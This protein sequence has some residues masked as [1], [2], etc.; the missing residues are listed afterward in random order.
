MTIFQKRKLDK[1]LLPVLLGSSF[2]T[3]LSIANIASADS[4]I[5]PGNYTYSDDTTIETNNTGMT[6]LTGNGSYTLDASGYTLTFTGVNNTN[7]Q[8]SNLVNVANSS[9]GT[10][11]ANEIVITDVNRGPSTTD[12]DIRGLRVESNSSATMNGNLTIKNITSNSNV[13]IGYTEGI[14]LGAGS[15][16]DVNGNL[17]VDTISSVNGNAIGISVDSTG[18]GSA[19]GNMTVTGTAEIKNISAAQEATAVEIVE[20]GEATFSGDLKIENV[21]SSGGNS[22]GLISGSGGLVHVEGNTSINSVEGFG[23]AIAVI[24]YGSSTATLDQDLTISSVTSTNQ[25]GVGVFVGSSGSTLTVGGN[26]QVDTIEGQSANGVA[27]YDSAS[28][29][30]DGDLNVSNVTALSTDAQGVFIGADLHVKGNVEIESVTGEQLANGLSVGGGGLGTLDQNITVNDIT[31]NNGDANGI[32]VTSGGRLDLGGDVQITSVT[33]NQVASGLLVKDNSIIDFAGDVAIDTVSSSDGQAFGMNF[34]NA[35]AAGANIGKSVHINSVSG[36]T[37]TAGINLTQGTSLEIGTNVGITNITSSDEEAAGIMIAPGSYGHSMTIGGNLFIDSVSGNQ[38]ASGIRMISGTNI[39]VGE[40]LLMSNINATN[41]RAA[42]ITTEIWGSTLTVEKDLV[43]QSVSSGG[44]ALGILAN[45]GGNSVA[46]SGDSL[47]HSIAGVQDTTGILVDY[48]GTATFGNLMIDSVS[49]SSGQAV[50]LHANRGGQINVSKGLVIQNISSSDTLAIHSEGTDSLVTANL[51]GGNF[52]SV[53]GNALAENQG[54]IQMVMDT[55][56]SQW[57]GDLQ[58]ANNGQIDL[59]FN[60]GLFI[61]KADQSTGTIQLNMAGNSQWQMTDSWNANLTMNGGHLFFAENAP[62]TITANGN[63]TM[64]GSNLHFNVDLGNG[65][66]DK[67]V[68]TNGI[69]GTG[70][71]VFVTSNGAAKTNGTETL[72][73]IIDSNYSGAQFTMADE[74]EAGGYTYGLHSEGRSGN[75]QAWYLGATGGISSTADAGINVFRASYLLNSADQQTLMQRLGDLRQGAKSNSIWVRPYGGSFSSNQDGKLAGFD[76]DYWG[77]QG[78][79]DKQIKLKSPEHNLYVGAMIGHSEGNLDLRS[80]GKG[81]IKSD[82]LGVYST[83]VHKNGFYSDLVLRYGWFDRDFNTHTASKHGIDSQGWSASLE[84]GKRHFI[85]PKKQEGWYVEPQ[86]QWTFGKQSGDSFTA[87]NGLHVRVS[88]M[89]TVTGR[90]G[91]NI[92]YEVKEGKRPINAYLKFNI[93]KEFDGDFNYQLNGSKESG[94]Y[95]GTRLIW[96]AGITSQLSQNHNLYL[97]IEKS[98]GGE[99]S[100]DWGIN[101]GYRFSW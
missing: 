70:G 81:D 22:R 40:S 72:D 83:F 55:P 29:T 99:F 14:Q 35:Y 1:V 38:N 86:T 90:V 78:G 11:T 62:E 73:V 5:G 66:G 59:T 19:S 65:T 12:N 77:I 39:S 80:R 84:I 45:G 6:A 25:Q 26:V 63:V 96:G 13:S 10:F 42:G 8:A 91:A 20:S 2:C 18:T 53:F 100:K 94:S 28:A 23:D 34:D 52:V 4:P 16:L 15:T 47:I 50:A 64:N 32:G 61:G 76:M 30:I 17:L 48:Y 88:D 3:M 7:G 74:V 9:T 49:S 21:E 31:S 75:T 85:D 71:N 33:G 46:V 95:G 98:S 43:I 41:G 27:V 101:A 37:T 82:T 68:I 93:E 60:D 89:T 87:S 57:I 51:A 69:S 54:K 56:T 36:K 44:E 67:L 79:Y 24:I 97:E 92:G 58:A